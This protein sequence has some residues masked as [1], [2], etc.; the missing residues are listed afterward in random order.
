MDVRPSALVS[1]SQVPL[2]SCPS[3]IPPGG[4]LDALVCVWVWL[5]FWPHNH[6]RCYGARY[7]CVTPIGVTAGIAPGNVC[8]RARRRAPLLWGCVARARHRGQ[9]GEA[10]PPACGLLCGSVGAAHA[11]LV[12]YRATAALPRTCGPAPSCPPR[13][14][15]APPPLCPMGAQYVWHSV[16][17]RA[18]QRP[19]VLLAGAVV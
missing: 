8:S 5:T 19:R 4:R 11:C 10:R 17:G 6:Y 2:F 3:L 9:A 12:T 14:R 7:W 16:V 1:S 13:R 15:H 18:A